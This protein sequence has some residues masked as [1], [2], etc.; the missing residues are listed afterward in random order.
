MNK[1]VRHLFIHLEVREGER[2]HDHKVITSTKCKDLNFAVE[3]YT[4]HYWGHG[5]RW[6]KDR[7]WFFW[8]G[9]I[10]ATLKNWNDLTE[11]EYQI[12][13]KFL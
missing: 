5:E 11:E 12:L 13:N 9:E 10:A 1:K 2:V 7:R 8:N 6:F 4:S 3:W